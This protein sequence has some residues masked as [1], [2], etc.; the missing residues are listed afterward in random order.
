[1]RWKAKSSA[2]WWTMAVNEA[3]KRL[4]WI[5]IYARHVME[6]YFMCTLAFFLSAWVHDKTICQWH[7]FLC[8]FTLSRQAY[9]QSKARSRHK[10]Y[11]CPV[12]FTNFSTCT[13]SEVLQNM[14]VISCI[15]SVV[16]FIPFWINWQAPFELKI[17]PFSFKGEKHSRCTKQDL[18]AFHICYL[19]WQWFST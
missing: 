13:C 11:E 5:C 8:L 19:L 4:K 18:R 1:M 14:A 2:I 7:S 16:A 6:K 10:K 17:L 12:P 15:T 3:W 9:E